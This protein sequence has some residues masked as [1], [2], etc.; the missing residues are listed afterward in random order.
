MA[1][2][3]PLRLGVCTSTLCLLRAQMGQAAPSA[4]YLMQVCGKGRE[5]NDR[6]QDRDWMSYS[7]YKHIH[8]NIK[9]SLEMGS[10]RVG[11]VHREVY[12]N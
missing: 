11:N 1:P 9:T 5:D 2:T 10:Q 3:V 4:E 12:Q 6:V 8:V 7:S